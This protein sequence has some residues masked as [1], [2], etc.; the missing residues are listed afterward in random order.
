[1]TDFE[2]TEAKFVLHVLELHEVMQV[3]LDALGERP[4]VTARDVAFRGFD[5]ERET[6]CMLY[7]QHFMKN[8]GLFWNVH[9]VEEGRFDAHAPMMPR[10]RRMLDV[11]ENHVGVRRK[12]RLDELEA[13][14][15]AGQDTS[16][17]D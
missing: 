1:M 7:A 17:A 3:S 5:A 8:E 14:V 12:L 2:T 16:A 11:W 6:I 13:I 4:G 10:Y 15:S 9:L